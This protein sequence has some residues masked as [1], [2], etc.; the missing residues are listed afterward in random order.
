[1]FAPTLSHCLPTYGFLGGGLE[2][3]AQSL[4][5]AGEKSLLQASNT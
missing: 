4:T 2:C 5:P 3:A 1:M